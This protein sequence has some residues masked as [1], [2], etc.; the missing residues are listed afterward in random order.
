M[1]VFDIYVNGRKV[2]RAGVGE[3]GVLSAVVTWVKLTGAA[4]QTARRMRKAG[5]ETRLHVGGLAGGTHRRWPGRMLSVGDRVS[6]RVATANSFDPP[7]ATE[8]RD[9]KLR[10]REERR[11]YLHLKRRFEPRHPR[12]AKKR[13]APGRRTTR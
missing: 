5:L 11:Y 12:Q 10:E 8:P 4:A 9:P 13:V 1:T 7:A 3:E 2:C 6:I